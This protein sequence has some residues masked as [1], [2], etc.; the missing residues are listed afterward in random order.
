MFVLLMLF[1]LLHV[2]SMSAMLI[3]KPDLFCL[4]VCVRVHARLSASVFALSK[5][6]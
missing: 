5:R 3:Y 4:C 1:D 6:V 2:A